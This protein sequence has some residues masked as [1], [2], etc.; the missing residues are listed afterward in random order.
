MRAIGTLALM[1]CLAYPAWGELSQR[2]LERIGE[3]MPS[4][5]IWTQ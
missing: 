4:R 3:W 2:D 1:L 5:R